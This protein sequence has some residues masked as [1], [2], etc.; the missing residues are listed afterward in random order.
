MTKEEADIKMADEIALAKKSLRMGVSTNNAEQDD[1]YL[2][3]AARSLCMRT[4][5]FCPNGC[6]NLDIFHSF[7]SCR[8][9]AYTDY[10]LST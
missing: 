2:H 7:M 8:K 3:E 5:G 6:G 10:G 1:A 9:C 4:A